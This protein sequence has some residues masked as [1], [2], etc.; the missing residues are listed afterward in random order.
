MH[1]KLGVR[2]LLPTSGGPHES[3]L[4]FH[5]SQILVPLSSFRRA[6]RVGAVPLEEH[7]VTRLQQGLNPG[8]EGHRATRLLC[9]H[10]WSRDLRADAAFQSGTQ[11]LLL[12]PIGLRS[13]LC[14]E[15]K[16]E[17]VQGADRNGEWQRFPRYKSFL[18]SSRMNLRIRRT[19]PTTTR[20][21]LHLL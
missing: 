17:P 15:G 7:A 18:E 1:R 10:F 6:L 12:R 8:D 21:R 11:C 3:S 13:Y 16:W 19:S 2:P 20:M 5:S 9:V 4:L 14:A